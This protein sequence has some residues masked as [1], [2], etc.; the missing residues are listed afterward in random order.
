MTTAATATVKACIVVRSSHSLTAEEV[1][2]WCRPR[3]VSYKKP[4]YVEF[5]SAAEV[6]RSVTGKILRGDLARR[7][8]TPDHVAQATSA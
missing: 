7:P 1:V 4:R 8:T 6:P 2:N 5:L 3:L